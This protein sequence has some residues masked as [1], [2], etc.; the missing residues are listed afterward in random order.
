MKAPADGRG[1]LALLVVLTGLGPAALQIFLPAIP[2]IQSHFMVSSALAQL[3]LSLS[4][5]SIAVATLLFGPLSDRIG[6]RPAVLIGLVVFLVGSIGSVLASSIVMLVVARVVQAAGGA[7]G[8]VI[9]RAMIRDRHGPEDAASMIAVV[10]TAMVVAPMISPILGGALTDLFGW[11]S[12][13]GAAG[14]AGLLILAAS[15]MSL[16]ETR[17][18]HVGVAG[19]PGLLHGS[20][21]L[22]RDRNF[23][24]YALQGAFSLALYYALLGG[25][26]YVVM[27]V[28]GGTATH[29]ALWFLP[30]AGMFM[31]GNLV[32]S[33]ISRSF[34]IDR[35]VL[36]GSIGNVGGA[37]LAV[38]LVAWVSVAP[39]AIFLP[40]ALVA[41]FQGLSVPNAQAGALSVEPKLAGTASGLAGFLQMALAAA[42]AQLV[43][44]VHDGT[45]WPMLLTMF[46]CALLSLLAFLPRA[47]PRGAVLAG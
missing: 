25:G 6:R 39:W 29:Y 12:T 38:L 23:L 47:F 36:V 21:R 30:V 24:A 20:L 4:T 34:G 27:E 11:R 44:T 16:P 5:L 22:L 43:G 35:M 18:A 8:M 19:G 31:A 15:A 45:A 37:G 14:L 41:F 9:V 13:F 3:T 33:R 46:G 10:T 26:P 7:A 40:T 2:A 42:A 1:F 17:P 32:A 28:M